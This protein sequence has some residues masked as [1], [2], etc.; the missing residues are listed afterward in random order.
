MEGMEKGGSKEEYLNAKRAAKRAVF[1]AKKRAEEMYFADVESNTENIFRIA[2]Q[3]RRENKDIVGDGCIGD[4]DGNLCISPVDKKKAWTEHCQRLLNT[5]F[6]WAKKNLPNAEAV[7]GSAP[8]ITLRMVSEAME[9]MKPGKAWTDRC[10]NRNAEGLCR[11]LLSNSVQPGKQNNYP[12]E[13]PR[14][15][16]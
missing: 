3:M 4:D 2:K 9:K 10:S 16:E 11:N 5:E 15:P 8:L 14:G 12:T 7:A 13:N 1:T 6:P